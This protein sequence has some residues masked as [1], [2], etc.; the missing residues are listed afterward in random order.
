VFSKHRHQ[1][2][3]L[4][5]RGHEQGR[6]ALSFSAPWISYK[7]FLCISNDSKRSVIIYALFMHYFS[8][9]LSASGRLPSGPYRDSVSGLRCLLTCPPLEKNLAGAHDRYAPF[10]VQPE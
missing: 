1:V 2:A 4:G 9:H 10:Q 5:A 8:K 6:L 7:L 3:A